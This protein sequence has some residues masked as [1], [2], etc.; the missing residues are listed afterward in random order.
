MTANSR[1]LP[2]PICS[3]G[4]VMCPICAQFPVHVDHNEDLV[5]A[6]WSLLQVGNEVGVIGLTESEIACALKSRVFLASTVYEGDLFA[7][8]AGSRPVPTAFSSY[9]SLLVYS[10]LPGKGDVI[11]GLRRR[12]HKCPTLDD[13]VAARTEDVAPDEGGAIAGLEILV[14]NVRRVGGQKF[15]QK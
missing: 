2:R 11:C 6:V 5:G 7:D 13:R 14:E 3:K 15:G 10:S 1:S 8:V 12:G 9:F 4:R